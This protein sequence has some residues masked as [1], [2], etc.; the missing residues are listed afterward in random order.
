MA[1]PQGPAPGAPAAPP[2]SPKQLRQ[3]IEH[4]D[5]VIKGLIELLNEPK[6]SLTKQKVADGAADIIA[7]GGFP[8]PEQKQALIVDL[9][10]VKNDDPD[11][12]NDLTTMLTK[13]LDMRAQLVGLLRKG[14]G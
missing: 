4:A 14:T 12:R 7:K 2:P 8:T 3:F 6:G 9:A 11:I 10:R 5:P 13:L 1:G